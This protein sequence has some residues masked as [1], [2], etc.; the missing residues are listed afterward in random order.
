[1]PA[2]FAGR[3]GSGADRAGSLPRPISFPKI[4]RIN[5][6]F[7]LNGLT[8]IN[9]QPDFPEL[10]WPKTKRFPGRYCTQFLNAALSVNQSLGCLDPNSYAVMLVFY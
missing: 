3:A 6:G 9:A 1:M 10:F 5:G 8:A 2:C 4:V 7:L